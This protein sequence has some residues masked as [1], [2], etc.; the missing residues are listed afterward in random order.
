MSLILWHGKPLP[1]YKHATSHVFFFTL[2]TTENAS[3]GR[4]EN[5][6]ESAPIGRSTG[7]PLPHQGI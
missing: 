6:K 3:I 5:I 4:K 1:V 2:T 7:D